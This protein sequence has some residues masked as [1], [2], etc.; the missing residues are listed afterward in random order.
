MYSIIYVS[1]TCYRI[2]LD[3][4]SSCM[5]T[6]M[7]FVI[8]S[9]HY[10][11]INLLTLHILIILELL[12]SALIDNNC[13]TIIKHVYIS[14]YNSSI[15]TKCYRLIFYY[16]FINSILINTNSFHLISCFIMTNISRLWRQL[17]YLKVSYNV[18]NILCLSCN[19]S[20]NRHFKNNSNICDTL[21]ILRE[22][23]IIKTISIYYD[24][25]CKWI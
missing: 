17:L 9:C 10:N 22:I 5:H 18:N 8:M 3:S 2:S 12:C 13:I 20:L 16:I 4:I 19:V 25:T 6:T 14:S 24:N 21:Q 15:S 23:S 1:Y 7:P 11:N